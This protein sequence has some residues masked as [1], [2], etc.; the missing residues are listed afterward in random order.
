M[1]I[2]SSDDDDDEDYGHDKSDI[3]AGREFYEKLD[4]VNRREDRLALRRQQLQRKFAI[5]VAV[6]CCLILGII[7]LFAVDPLN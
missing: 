4:A 6:V 3:E 7:L 2:D 1:F 5:A